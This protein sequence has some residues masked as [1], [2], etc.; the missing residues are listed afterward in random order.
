MLPYL[1][2]LDLL[3]LAANHAIDLQ[4]GIVIGV[5]ISEADA[6]DEALVGAAID[7]AVKESM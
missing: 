2:V 4:S 6:M 1:T 3:A 7:Q 5:P